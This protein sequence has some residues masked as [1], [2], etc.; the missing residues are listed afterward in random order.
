[1]NSGQKQL[2]KAY[3][4]VVGNKKPTTRKSFR[5]KSFLFYKIEPTDQRHSIVITLP[6]IQIEFKFDTSS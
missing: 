5:F 1:M 4:R 2:T 3:E 6:C